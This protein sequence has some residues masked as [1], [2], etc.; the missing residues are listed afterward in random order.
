MLVL[1][2]FDPVACF[3]HNL[4]ARSSSHRTPGL[5]AVL[6]QEMIYVSALTFVCLVGET[7][8]RLFTEPISDVSSSHKG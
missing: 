5:T 7:L 2:F 3:S 8:G 4:A 1:G 6:N